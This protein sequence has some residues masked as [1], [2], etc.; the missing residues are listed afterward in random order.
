MTELLS[1]LLLHLVM[2]L[3]NL[4]PGVER[5]EAGAGPSEAVEVHARGVPASGP[6]QIAGPACRA[7]ATACAAARMR[8]QLTLPALSVR[9]C[10]ACGAADAGVPSG[11]S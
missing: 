6:V 9:Q 2:I 10:A 4:V 3:V 8:W 1:S 11:E 5:V 7:D